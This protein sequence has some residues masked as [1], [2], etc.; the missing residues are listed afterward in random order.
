MFTFK[1]ICET[2]D[3]MV[4]LILLNFYILSRLIIHYVRVTHAN[5]FKYIIFPE[6]SNNTLDMF[7]IKM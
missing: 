6:N 7:L 4:S 1:P 3:Y 5:N 2:C